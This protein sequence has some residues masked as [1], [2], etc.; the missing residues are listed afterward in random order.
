MTKAGLESRLSAQL[1]TLRAEHS[2]CE[3]KIAKLSEDIEASRRK[4]VA[5]ENAAELKTRMLEKASGVVDA[6][7]VAD[8]PRKSIRPTDAQLLDDADEGGG[9]I[10]KTE[11]KDL[12]AMLD[13]DE[14]TAQPPKSDGKVVSK[15]AQGKSPLAAFGGGNEK[16]DEKLK[17]EPPKTYTVEEGDTLMRISVK[18]YGT[19]RRWRDIREANKTVISPDGRVRAG[20]VINLP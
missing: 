20:Q 8:A 9:R 10:S 17:L 3:R 12:R 1:E 19:N 11:I 18:F 6:S 4:I 13:E 15:D 16:K 5:L 7:S 2:K 14:R